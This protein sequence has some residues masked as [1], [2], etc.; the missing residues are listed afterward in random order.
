MSGEELRKLFLH[1]QLSECALWFRRNV[2]K[3]GIRKEDLKPK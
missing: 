1:F 2:A 3:R